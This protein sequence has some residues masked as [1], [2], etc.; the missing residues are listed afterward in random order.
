MSA[1][2]LFRDNSIL[3]PRT[4]NIFGYIRRCSEGY[5]FNTEWQKDLM[6]MSSN[7]RTLKFFED[8]ESS[9]N[10]YDRIEF[11]SLMNSLEKDDILIVKDLFTI[12]SS[13]SQQEEIL[14]V[15]KEKGVSIK[16]LRN[17]KAALKGAWL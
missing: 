6:K 10:P 9:D 1:S 17:P 15:L 11:Q 13:V 2:F 7:S 12:S 3:S 5:D 8:S 4:R 14:S 16:L